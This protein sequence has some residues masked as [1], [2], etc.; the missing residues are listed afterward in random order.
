MH[1]LQLI[2][3]IRKHRLLSFYKIPVLF[4]LLTKICIC[5]KSKNM[6]SHSF[7]S[8]QEFWWFFNSLHYNSKTMY[9]CS[10]SAKARPCWFAEC[11]E[12]LL[13]KEEYNLLNNNE[14]I[15]HHCCDLSSGSFR[16]YMMVM[17]CSAGWLDAKCHQQRYTC[18]LICTNVC[19]LLLK[20]LL[21]I[22]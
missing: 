5:V 15:F 1:I 2:I 4:Q 18:I 20:L 3:V 10:V 7:G 22:L 13:W 16:M 9:K 17:A 19:V 11:S 14:E 8:I 21:I 6:S 12:F